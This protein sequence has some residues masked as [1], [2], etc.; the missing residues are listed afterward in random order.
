M[1]SLAVIHSQKATGTR[2]RLP[3]RWD[4]QKQEGLQREAGG[5]G[6]V[7]EARGASEVVS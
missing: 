4:E 2:A 7:Q 1:L 5:G 6:S 3:S